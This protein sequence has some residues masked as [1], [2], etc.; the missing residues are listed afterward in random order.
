MA[1]LLLVTWYSSR[2]NWKSTVD[3]LAYDFL[4]TTQGQFF[5]NQLSAYPMFSK[6][7][8][9]YTNF[10]TGVEMLLKAQLDWRTSTQMSA[11]PP[12]DQVIFPSGHDGLQVDVRWTTNRHPRGYPPM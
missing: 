1:P 6:D 9:S 2:N 12:E 7:F 5:F 8:T 4:T 11:G 3:F 10:D